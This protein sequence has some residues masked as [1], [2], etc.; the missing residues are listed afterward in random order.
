MWEYFCE[1]LNLKPR[2]AY[3]K[4]IRFLLLF[5]S[6]STPSL[7]LNVVNPLF[8]FNGFDFNYHAIAQKGNERASGDTVEVPFLYINGLSA[9]I[10]SNDIGLDRGQLGQQRI[11]HF[12]KWAIS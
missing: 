7:S 1:H 6:V 4:S 5:I 12:K 11:V 3:E 9:G 8:E 10:G 2:P